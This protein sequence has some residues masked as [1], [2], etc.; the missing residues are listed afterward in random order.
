MSPIA[1]M[2]LFVTLQPGIL[3]TLPAV[4]RSVFMSG[5]TSVH[6][7]FV[8]A[9]VF[10]IA[11]HLLRRVRYFEGFAPFG[12]LAQGFAT[13]AIQV[14]PSPDVKAETDGFTKEL[15]SSTITLQRASDIAKRI[16]DQ[17]VTMEM[18]VNTL[19][20]ESTSLSKQNTVEAKQ[21]KKTNTDNLRQANL[22]LDLYQKLM[23]VALQ[24]YNQ[25][26]QVARPTTATKKR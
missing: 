12:S 18:A 17:L 19:K 3:L 22:N 9:F 7:V 10:L 23:P 11:V 24:K 5:K 26:K 6:A 20:D 4:G 14:S 2:L 15:A 1:M 8:H 13:K 25:L 16:D 21:K